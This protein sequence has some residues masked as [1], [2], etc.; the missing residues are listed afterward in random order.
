MNLE[1]KKGS[2]VWVRAECP[3]CLGWGHVL[4]LTLSLEPCPG[5]SEDVKCNEGRIRYQRPLQ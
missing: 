2:P 4:G 5:P 3:K 1:L